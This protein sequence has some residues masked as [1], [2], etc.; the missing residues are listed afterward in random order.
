MSCTIQDLALALDGSPIGS[1][2]VKASPTTLAPFVKRTGNVYRV[3]ENTSFSVTTG[4]DGLWTLTLPWPSETREGSHLQWQLTLPDGTMFAGTVP[5]AVAGPLTLDQLTQTYGWGKV[6]ALAQ[7]VVIAVGPVG[8]QGSPGG[9]AVATPVALGGVFVDQSPPL[10]GTPVALTTTSLGAASSGG[11]TGVASLD[12]DGLVPLAQLAGIG[13]AQIAP[14]SLMGGAQGQLSLTA[15]IV[16]SQIASVDAARLTGGVVPDAN[17]PASLARLTTYNTWA[18][19]TKTSTVEAPAQIWNAGSLTLGA[20][21]ALSRTYRFVARSLGGAFT[22]TKAVTVG[23]SGPPTSAGA[24]IT[25]GWALNVES[26]AL[27]MDG[28]IPATANYGLISLGG[29]PWDGSTSGK[30]AGN[31]SGTY[32]AINTVGEASDFLHFM[33]AGTTRMR[34]RGDHNQSSGTGNV[35]QLAPLIQQSGTAAYN[36]ILLNVTETGT[37]SGAKAFLRIQKSS[38]DQFVIDNGGNL[39]LKDGATIAVGTSTGTIFGTSTTE[40]MSWW[41]AT[42]VVKGTVTG[43]RGSNAALASLLTLLASYGLLTDSSS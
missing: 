28:T 36:G 6:A 32:I 29:S 30:F 43:S 7:P 31:S 41:N 4:A 38:V 14:L 21:L 8:P 9:N 10:G 24:T 39:T 20:S 16:S 22:A 26:G 33:E 37:G 3:G 12:S 19:A 17:L 18:T 23:I 35:L 15:G 1:K 34:A 13:A 11:V 42:P 2:T 40:K 25:N 27:L 5:E